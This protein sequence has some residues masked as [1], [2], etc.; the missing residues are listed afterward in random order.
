MF[1]I[2]KEYSSLLRNIPP[3]PKVGPDLPS[4]W[5]FG[6]RKGLVPGQ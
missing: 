6:H 1:E 5:D 3:L 2:V 4:E